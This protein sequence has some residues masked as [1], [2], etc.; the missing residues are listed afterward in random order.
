MFFIKTLNGLIKKPKI[1]IVVIGNC[2]SRPLAELLGILSDNVEIIAIA[3]VHLLKSN[4]LEEYITAFNDADFIVAQLVSD[5][6]PCEFVRTCFLEEH[7]KNKLIK[8]L[9]LYYTGYTPDWIYIR[10]KDR[11]TLKGPMGDYHN[12]TIFDCWKSGLTA[13]ESAQKLDDLDHNRVYLSSSYQ[14]IKELRT[15]E[16]NTDLSIVDFIEERYSF[17]RLF[18]TMN[19]PSYKLLHEYAKRIL[20]NCN[21]PFKGINIPIKNEPLGQFCPKIN[22]IAAIN[23]SSDKHHHGIA[24]STLTQTQINTSKKTYTS[25]EIASIF[26]TIYDINQSSI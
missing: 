8:I 26:Y 17:E 22:P 11:I 2:Q 15:R 13:N 25:S 19:H 7:Y 10:T 21:I 18:F 24:F 9:N 14:S 12:Q 4:Q 5:N 16:I 6:Y 20:Q 1:K 23:F 3:V